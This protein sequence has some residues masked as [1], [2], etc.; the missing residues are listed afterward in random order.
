MQ[1]QSGVILATDKIIKYA[2]VGTCKSVS[3]CQDVVCVSKCKSR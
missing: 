1:C 2:T 3:A